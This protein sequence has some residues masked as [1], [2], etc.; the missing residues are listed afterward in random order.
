MDQIL[1]AFFAMA[2]GLLVLPWINQGIH[3][4]RQTQ[5]DVTTAQ[6]QQQWNAAVS[7]YVSQNS[8]TLQTTATATTP[9]TLT[10]PMIQAANVGLPSTFAPTNPFN[11]TWIAQV[12]QP[13]VGTL[14][15]LSFGSG[16]T[17][18]KD[19]E[20]GQIARAAGASGGFI[21][22]NNTGAYPGGAAFGYGTLGSWK[23]ATAGYAV[24]AGGTPASLLTFSNGT[25]SSNYLY[26][27]LI[28]GQPQLNDMNTSLGLNHNN[29]TSVGQLQADSGDGVVIGSSTFYGDAND[30]AI[31]QNGTLYVQNQAGTAPGPI[32]TGTA[33]VTG[34]ADVSGTIT[35][36]GNV[37]ATGAVTSGGLLTAQGQIQING[38]AV[39]GTACP[40]T[41]RVVQDGAGS[42]LSCQSGVWSKLSGDSTTFFMVPTFGGGCVSPNPAT[43]SCSCPSGTRYVSLSGQASSNGYAFDRSIYACVP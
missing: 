1:G 8:A 31:K 25:L 26:R 10:V 17:A 5:I 37:T 34:D 32:N 6:Q 2:A 40:E 28:P 20:L 36:G 41:G 24:G 33:T 38:T 22:T 11:Q 18:I 27:N 12:S 29:I 35:V 43:G 13:T 14:Q 15:V 42:L 9:V 21:P 7:V 4:A 19:T 16:G 39:E 3:T 23:I 30:T